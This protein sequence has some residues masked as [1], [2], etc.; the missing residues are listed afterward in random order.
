MSAIS[1]RT[2]VILTSIVSGDFVDVRMVPLIHRCRGLPL[3]IRT[4]PLL[5]AGIGD[6]RVQVRRQ[7]ACIQMVLIDGVIECFDVGSRC[8]SFGIA[9]SAENVGNNDSRKNGYN[10]DDDENFNQRKASMA[11]KAI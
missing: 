5:I 10:N 3:E 8:A 4:M 1:L 7:G 2:D 9:N 6:Q 11:S